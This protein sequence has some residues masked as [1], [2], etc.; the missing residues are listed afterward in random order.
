MSHRMI[1]LIMPIWAGV[2]QAEDR[3]RD[4]AVIFY[5]NLQ[6]QDH[7]LILKGYLRT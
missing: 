3:G 2:T 1:G 5:C 7:D 6:D 4:I